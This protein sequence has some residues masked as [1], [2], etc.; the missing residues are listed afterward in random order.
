MACDVSPVAMFYKK[1]AQIRT[2]IDSTLKTEKIDKL[3]RYMAEPLE[4]L[5]TRV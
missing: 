5:H 4:A 2:K 3:T 1:A